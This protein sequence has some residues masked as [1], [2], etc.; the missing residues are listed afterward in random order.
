MCVCVCVCVCACVCVCVRLCVCVRVCLCVGGCVWVGV[1]PV[2]AD[3]L[4]RTPKP[5]SQDSWPLVTG[6]NKNHVGVIMKMYV[7]YKLLKY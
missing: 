7:L 3:Y 2:L 6:C 1:K 4:F 5:V